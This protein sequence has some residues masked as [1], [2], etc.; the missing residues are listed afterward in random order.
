[1]CSVWPLVPEV[2]RAFGRDELGSPPAA[3]LSALA[4]GGA[5]PG[6]GSDAP[7]SQYPKAP[8]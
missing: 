5:M 4:R 1:M 7:G 2:N 3:G 6:P 8:R